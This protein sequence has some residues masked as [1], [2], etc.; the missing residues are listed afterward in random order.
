MNVDSSAGSII[1]CREPVNFA[2]EGFPQPQ[3]AEPSR[4]R[5]YLRVREHVERAAAKAAASKSARAIHHEL[6]EL[7]G[8]LARQSNSTH[9]VKQDGVDAATTRTE[10]GAR[11]AVGRA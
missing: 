2:S 3:S 9:D 5:D 1:I 7:Y 8:R 10:F 4:D 6:A 11:D